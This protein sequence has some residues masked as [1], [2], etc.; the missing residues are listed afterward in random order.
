MKGEWTKVRRGDVLPWLAGLHVTLN[1]KG[2]IV[3][4]KTTFERL[5]APEA[6]NLLYD[7]PNN[8]I[9]LQP[10]R[11]AMTDA[12]PL[13]RSNSHGARMV[14]AFRLLAEFKI[15]V[16]DT[17]EFPDAEIDI[18]GILVLNLRRARISKRYVS[19][20]IRERTKQGGQ[21]LE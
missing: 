21:M 16:C 3:M 12:Y 17:L 9:G 15:D 19:R 6:V 13:V 7:R 14:R 8:R 1:R 11:A 5:G 4:N 18:D 10:T 20:M 2:Q